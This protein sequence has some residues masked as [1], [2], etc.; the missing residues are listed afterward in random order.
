MLVI[1]NDRH[2]MSSV[3]TMMID[4]TLVKLIFLNHIILVTISYILHKVNIHALYFFS[5]MPLVVFYSFPDGNYTSFFTF[6]H[7][8]HLSTSHV[9]VIIEISPYLNR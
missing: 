2:K 3:S 7:P 4:L 1:L 5:V 8:V 6:I 9:K